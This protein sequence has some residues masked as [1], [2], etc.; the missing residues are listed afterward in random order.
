MKKFTA[1]FLMVSLLGMNCAT[2]KPTRKEKEWILKKRKHG[3]K[4]IIQKID[5]AQI[6]AELIAVKE[7]SLLLMERDSG[8]DVS[9]DISEIEAI[10]IINRSWAGLGLIGGTATGFALGYTI[11]GSGKSGDNW[12]ATPIL[13][14]SGLLFGLL[15][16]VSGAIAGTD[17]TIQVEGKSDS[18]I[19]EILEN[20]RWKAR[21][22]NYQ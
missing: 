21:L 18:E 14:G 15:G 13:L 4:L 20:L 16:T 11:T 12:F 19:Q 17:E 7:N 5:E 1:L 10:R 8:A 3:T 6:R 2:I 22:R 9:I